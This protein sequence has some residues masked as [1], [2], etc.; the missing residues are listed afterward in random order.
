MAGH[1]ELA[2]GKL[3][4]NSGR[5]V[6]DAA[7]VLANLAPST[8]GGNTAPGSDGFARGI[9][10]PATV[11]YCFNAVANIS[12]ASYVPRGYV[13]IPVFSLSGPDAALFSLGGANGGS[14]IVAGGAFDVTNRSSFSVTINC[15]DDQGSFTPINVT[16]TN[17]ADALILSGHFITDTCNTAGY[18]V[19]GVVLGTVSPVGPDI[20]GQVTLTDPSGLFAFYPAINSIGTTS[21]PVGKYGSYPVTLSVS[22]SSG[23]LTQHVTLYVVAEERPVIKFVPNKVYASDLYM[24]PSLTSHLTSDAVLG[25][26]LAYSDT[27][28]SV[29]PALVNETDSLVVSQIGQ[30]VPLAPLTAGVGHLAVFQAVSNTGKISQVPVLYY[31]GQGATLPSSNMTWSGVSGLTN[32]QNNVVV[33]TAT[34]TGMTPTNWTIL[35]VNSDFQDS[36]SFNGTVQGAP[37]PRYVASASG[38]TVTVTAAYLSAQTDTLLLVA[39]DGSGTQCA[40]QVT[41]TASDV[42]ATGPAVTIT[43]GATA[44]STVFPKWNTA[45]DAAWTNKAA[46]SGLSVLTPG[47][48]YTQTATDLNRDAQGSGSAQQFPPCPYSLK[49]PSPTNP[50]IF[51][52]Q[53]IPAPYGGGQAAL[54]ATN[55]DTTYQNLVVRSLSN[56]Y[57]GGGNAGAIYQIGQTAGNCT[58][59]DVKLYN[60]DMGFVSGVNDNST[61]TLLRCVFGYCGVGEGGLTHNFYIGHADAAILTNCLSISTCQVHL[62]KIRSRT[63]TI[64]TCNFIQGMNGTPG[65]SGCVDIPDG[66]V[67]YMK[68]PG[69][70]HIGA[71]PNNNGNFI[72]FCAEATNGGPNEL[73][74]ENQLTVDGYTFVNTV[75]PGSL[76]SLVYGVVMFSQNA[77]QNGPPNVSPVNGK[78]ASI[79]VK[80]C[81]FY[82]ISPA[83]WFKTQNPLNP[84]IDGGGNVEVTT[85]P[86]D[87]LPIDPSTGS[88]IVPAL[89][90]KPSFASPVASLG[91]V[92]YQG[93]CTADPL[94]LQF[95]IAANAAVGTPLLNT[96]G[97]P[98]VMSSY[99]QSGVPLTNSVFSL[100]TDQV[101][102]GYFAINSSTGVI[103]VAKAGVPDSLRWVR[104]QVTGKDYK[105]VTQ[106]YSM[107]IY[108]VVGNGTVSP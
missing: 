18:G 98:A 107:Y 102:D 65:A 81:T 68:G 54:G 66:G 76:S 92:N 1:I 25:N 38:N 99:D 69:V 74:D 101:N 95:R 78:Y 93:A 51:D 100:L 80:N 30:L 47:G 71:Q 67:H 82:N 5:P 20:T 11:A 24:Q 34:V 35:G 91:A 42:R 29:P 77:L 16:V 62:A 41:V 60:S 70:I 105:G 89:A 86:V 17:T 104:W 75:A 40:L 55:Y 13:G 27:G 14:L 108:V 46:Y 59:I 83:N 97:N 56:L 49:G 10:G 4:L 45:L 3:L 79:V 72:Q 87:L 8:G 61:I 57:G 84:V 37:N 2:N 43:P 106:T 9:Y 28:I 50:T 33:G 53:G 96:S 22:T 48:I 7:P 73:W 88:N 39:R 90:P 64:T 6:F 19:P 94:I 36:S 32:A 52:F 58:L 31:V 44:T 26:V 23:T 15:Q 63:S 85:W 103:T 12:I 21:S